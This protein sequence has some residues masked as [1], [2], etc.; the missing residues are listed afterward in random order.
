MFN[1]LRIAAFAPAVLSAFAFG[2]APVR[3]QDAFTLPKPD[4]SVVRLCVLNNKGD[5]AAAAQCYAT[6]DSICFD[7][8]FAHYS[9]CLPQEVAYWNAALTR[10]LQRAGAGQM[11]SGIDAG[12]AAACPSPNAK[13]R[14]VCEARYLRD[15]TVRLHIQRVWGQPAVSE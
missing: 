4:L 2:S 9:A 1:L 14:Q 13:Y 6:F 7:K 11:R 3:A 12:M 10:E 15:H 8:W 5:V